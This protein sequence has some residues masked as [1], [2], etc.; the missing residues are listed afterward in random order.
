MALAGCTARVWQTD[1]RTTLLR[2]RREKQT[3]EYI[4]TPKTSLDDGLKLSLQ[5]TYSCFYAK[6][7][8]SC[9]DVMMYY[10]FEADQSQTQ[11]GRGNENRSRTCGR[12]PAPVMQW[13]LLSVVC[14]RRI[15]TNRQSIVHVSSCVQQPLQSQLGLAWVSGMGARRYDAG[16][17]GRGATPILRILTSCDV[18]AAHVINTSSKS[19]EVI[20]N[21]TVNQQFL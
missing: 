10:T 1:G 11:N 9:A 5:Q 2:C 7:F 21:D 19:I 8:C 12:H 16:K 20:F 6:C 3:N 14:L 4:E 18:I 15:V 17:G 13:T